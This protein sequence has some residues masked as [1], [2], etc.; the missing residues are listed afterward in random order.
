MTSRQ[1][2]KWESVS[3]DLSDPMCARKALPCPMGSV[4]MSR[5]MLDSE[6]SHQVYNMI[7]KRRKYNAA[8]KS[9]FLRTRHCKHSFST[10]A[11]CV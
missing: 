6:R 2:V 1:I 11:S 7:L 4:V 10:Y 5:A 9:N 3:S 8:V